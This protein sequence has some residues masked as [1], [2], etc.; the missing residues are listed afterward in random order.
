MVFLYLL[1]YYYSGDFTPDH[2]VLSCDLRTSTVRNPLIYY[3]S[4]LLC[5]ES[6][7]QPSLL[8]SMSHSY[9]IIPYY[10]SLLSRDF[11]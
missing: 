8:N 9:T 5:L 10:R 4:F 1:R 3:P 7:N 2:V 6:I 11:I